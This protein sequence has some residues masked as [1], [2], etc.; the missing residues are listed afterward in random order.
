MVIPVCYLIQFQGCSFVLTMGVLFLLVSHLL[1]I[2]VI[3]VL[4]IV[5]MIVILWAVGVSCFC[6]CVSLLYSPTVPVGVS[7]QCPRCVT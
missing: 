2:G 3:F 7:D 6:C 1:S 5:V 4:D